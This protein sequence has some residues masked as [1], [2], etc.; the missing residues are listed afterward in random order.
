MSNKEKAKLNKSSIWKCST[1]L[2][3]K[4]EFS[5]NIIDIASSS[6]IIGALSPSSPNR[7][8]LGQ[9]LL[10]IE[11]KVSTFTKTKIPLLVSNYFSK[12]GTSEIPINNRLQYKLLLL[13][14]R[15]ILGE[16]VFDEVCDD[17]LNKNDSCSVALAPSIAFLTKGCFICKSTR[18]FHTFCHMCG[19]IHNVRTEMNVF[20]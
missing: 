8:T 1:C 9:I 4:Q 13:N 14:I 16:G 7:I 12:F 18:Y 2:S 11:C 19:Y 6:K 10:T 15:N 20:E 5:L 3:G 17:I